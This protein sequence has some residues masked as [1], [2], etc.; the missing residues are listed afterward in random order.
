MQVNVKHHINKSQNPHDHLNRCR[1]KIGK[2]QHP[3][4]IKT[5]TKVGIERIYINI[6]KAAS[7]KLAAN[8]IF[9]GEKLKSFLLKY[10]T[11][12]PTLTTFI[13]HSIRS[14]SHSNQ[15]KEEIQGMQ[16]CKGRKCKL[17]LYADDMILYIENPRDSIQE[18]LDLIKEFS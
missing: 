15:T 3:F 12:M 4:M 7:A 1:K 13:Q 17:L 16:K 6:I 8:I 9:N 2:I 18:L 10:G 5:L 11:R 14:P